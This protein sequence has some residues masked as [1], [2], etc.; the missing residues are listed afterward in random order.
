MA[1]LSPEAAE[2][3]CAV[4][5]VFVPGPPHDPTPGAADVEADRF[6]SHYLDFLLPGLA[7][8]LPNLLDG[9][10]GQHFDG[11]RFA[12][13]AVEEREAVLDRLAEHEVEQLRILPDL[14]GL[15]SIAAVYGEW[16]GQDADGNLVRTPLG[17]QL[18]G[19]EGPVRGRPKLLREGL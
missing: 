8:G 5:E 4:A 12:A 2:T 3:L 17:W 14:L 15:L 13:L 7:S 18:T 6:L 9:L 10:A 19:F 1:P 11:R 16:T